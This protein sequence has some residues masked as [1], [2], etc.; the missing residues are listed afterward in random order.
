LQ[1][2]DAIKEWGMSTG[3]E[4]LSD[5]ENLHQ[6]WHDDTPV[7]DKSI[8]IG[9]LPVAILFMSIVFGASLVSPHPLLK[10]FLSLSPPLSFYLLPSP[11]LS[12]FPSV[13]SSS[14]S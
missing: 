7:D 6:K 12:S 14:F 1:A 8:F 2:S 11:P 13:P 5:F 3:L 10:S 9:L 4:R